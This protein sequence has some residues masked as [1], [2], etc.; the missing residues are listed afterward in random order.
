MEMWHPSIAPQQQ[1]NCHNAA[2]I[3][4]FLHKILSGGW[5]VTLSARGSNLEKK[6]SSGTQGIGK[7]ALRRKFPQIACNRFT[8]FFDD[9][10]NSRHAKAE[11]LSNGV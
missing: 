6:N 8:H 11:Q 3:T 7:C 9:F 10:V 5:K 1:G 4:H 2:Y